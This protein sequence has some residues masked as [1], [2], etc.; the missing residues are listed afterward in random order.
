[1]AET[2]AEVIAGAV[3]VAVAAGFLAFAL[4]GRGAVAG[5]GKAEYRA[6]FRSVEGIRVGT[7]IRLAGV[8]VGQITSLTLNPQTYFADATLTLPAD[9][10]LP[11]DSAILIQSEG[12]LG[13]AYVEVQPGGSPTDYAPGDEIE[14]T[15]GAVSMIS[16][17]MKFLDSSGGSKDATPAPE[18]AP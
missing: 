14:D 11:D 5:G 9:L 10:A 17:L 16:L 18:T 12:L 8:K 15:Q 6:A 7:D 13:G 3:V 2:R 1:M 4:Q